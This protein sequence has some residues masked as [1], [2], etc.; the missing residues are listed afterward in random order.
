MKRFMM[1]VVAMLLVATT[2]MA[3]C[4]TNNSYPSGLVI[5]IDTF[6]TAYVTYSAETQPQGW[7]I[8][9]Q[10]RSTV[11]L[12]HQDEDLPWETLTYV[13]VVWGF[14]GGFIADLSSYIDNCEF[15]TETSNETFGVVKATYR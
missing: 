5:C 4:S 8:T 9:I 2:A 6:C 13:P 12:H 15:S 1:I 11:G 10:N 7:R 3:D 14:K